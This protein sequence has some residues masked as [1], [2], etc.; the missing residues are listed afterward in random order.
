VLIFA[1]SLKNSQAKNSPLVT[2]LSEIEALKLKVKEDLKGKVPEDFIDKI[3]SSPELTYYPQLMLKSLTW[4]ESKLPYHQFLTPERLKRAEKFYKKHFELLQAMEEKFGVEKEVLVGI[5][6]VETNFGKNTGR[7]PVLNVFY[8]LAISGRKEVFKPFAEKAGISLSD[9][10]V[11]KKWQNRSK[12][13]YKEL[14]AFIQIC[15]QNHWD[16]FEVKGSLFGAF[17]YPQFV[18]RSYLIYGYDWNKDGVV[19]LYDM[20]DALSSIANY[21]K[22]EG[23][24]ISASEEEKKR[25]I[26]TYN[27]SEPYANAVFA[28]AKELRGLQIKD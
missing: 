16:P 24:K 11:Y 2:P 18:P 23:Y 20:E 25:V 8:S 27:H 19:D 21:L 26:M 9:P 5:F 15:Y 6:M 10:A 17:G 13:A 28:I 7:W 12:W 1:L 4:N 22:K 14:L 3:F